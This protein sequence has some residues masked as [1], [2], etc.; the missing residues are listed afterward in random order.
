M[1]DAEEQ[2][3]FTAK[4]LLIILQGVTTTLRGNADEASVYFGVSSN[5]T[6]IDI[7]TDSVIIKTSGSEKMQITIILTELAV[8]M[9]VPPHMMLN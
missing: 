8:D 9:K 4:Y 3:F 7:C 6:I 1:N 5:Y 2:V